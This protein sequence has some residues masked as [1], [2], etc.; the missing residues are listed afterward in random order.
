ML[1]RV[2]AVSL[3]SL[4]IA[5]GDSG[6][7]GDEG[8]ASPGG[9][10]GSGAQGSGAEGSGAGSSEGGNGSGEGGAPALLPVCVLACSEA[11]GCATASPVTDADNWAC[12]AQR[13]EYLGCLSDA[14]CQSAYANPA[15]VCDESAFIPTCVLACQSPADCATATPLTDADNWTCTFGLCGYLGCLSDGE[16]QETYANA[17]Y[18]C[19]D[20]LAIPGCFLDCAAPADCATASV[21]TD[22]DNWARNDHCEYL[23]CQSTSECQEGFANP[24]YVCE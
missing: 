23:G 19:D 18:E 10:N 14:E 22:A 2:A 11:A 20:G 8:A 3:F 9:G 12:T 16:C 7:P 17:A 5:C 13:C 15:Y 6:S 21:L 4:S 24:D 1:E